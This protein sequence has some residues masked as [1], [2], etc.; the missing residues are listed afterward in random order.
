MGRGGSLRR[1]IQAMTGPSRGIFGCQGNDRL[2]RL[3]QPIQ[4]ARSRLPGF[5]THFR[6]TRGLLN[7]AEGDILRAM[8]LTS[9]RLHQSFGHKGID[10]NSFGIASLPKGIQAEWVAVLGQFPKT[11][12]H[13]RPT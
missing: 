8:I 12:C 11:G 3:F 13:A 7:G 10:R 2:R 1:S 6:G 5:A 9:R 4:G